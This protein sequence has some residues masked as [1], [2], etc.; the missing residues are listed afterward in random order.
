VSC[1]TWI[2][3]DIVVEPTSQS[4]VVIADAAEAAL[5]KK[6][7]NCKCMASRGS[8][9]GLIPTNLLWITPDPNCPRIFGQPIVAEQIQRTHR[10]RLADAMDPNGSPPVQLTLDPHPEL[11]VMAFATTFTAPIGSL[12]TPASVL[13]ALAIDGP[14]P[15]ER[16]EPTRAA[17][18]DM[19]RVGGYKPT[20]RGKPA[21]EYLVRA[22]TEG[23][24]SSINVAVDACNAASLHSGFPISVVDLDRA[25]GPFRITIAPAGT[26]YVFNVSGQ[27]IDLSGLVC[28]Y[29]ATGPCANAVRDAQR[30][31]T[32]P[33]TRRTLSIIWGCAGFEDR[34]NETD[35]WYREMIESSGGAIARITSSA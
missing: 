24:L 26:T 23:A 28:L 22:A 35:R 34:L 15:I 18:R 19:L 9:V 21:S 25:T 14:A 33:D 27:E 20:G 30:T 2:I 8:R 4:L 29:D 10:P 13:A 7:A 1:L 11:R 5:M 16:D 32:T 31:K 6:S 12:G 3:I 17:V